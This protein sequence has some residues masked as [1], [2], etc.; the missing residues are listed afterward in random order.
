VTQLTRRNVLLLAVLMAAATTFVAYL[1]LARQ[2]VQALSRGED[3]VATQTMVV[4]AKQEIQ[5]LQLLRSDWFVV[6]QVKADGVPRDA[7]ATPADLNG[8]VALVNMSPGQVVTARQVARRSSDLGLAY[9]VR[10]PYRAVTVALDPIIGVAGFPKPGNHV[11]VLATFTTDFGMVTRTV[12]QDVEILALGSESRPK[13]VD[14]DTGKTTEGR[15]QQTATL[16]V[17][18]GEAEKLI[19]AENRGKLQLALRSPE[20]STYRAHSRMTETMVT[21]MP[22]PPRNGVTPTPVATKPAPAASLSPAQEQLLKEAD[23]L[24]HEQGAR[25]PP[26][27]LPSASGLSSGPRPASRSESPAH[28]ITVIHGDRVEKVPIKQDRKPAHAAEAP[29]TDAGAAVVLPSTSEAR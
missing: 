21:S 5:P 19:L 10:P 7:V 14:P 22:V 17:L 12:L 24:V 28:V 9:A 25:T 8:K 4:V 27:V 2:Q 23:R 20:D 29:S 3:R 1:F 16:S 18:P 13:E 11:D 26:Q 15:L 6:K